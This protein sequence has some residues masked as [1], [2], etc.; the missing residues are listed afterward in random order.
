MKTPRLRLAP[1][2]TGMYH[3]GVPTLENID[4]F[5]ARAG[6]GI[7][8]CMVGNIATTSVTVP[9]AS[10]GI[11]SDNL[12]WGSLA[13]A[14]RKAGSISGIQLSATLPGYR[15]QRSFVALDT[16]TAMRQ[17][18]VLFDQMSEYDWQTLGDK[19]IQS[20]ELCWR[21]G[22]EHVQLHAAH[23][24]A[25]SLI[26][27]PKINPEK[28]GWKALISILKLLASSNQHGTSLRV[29]WHTG[30][31]YDDKRQARILEVWRPFIG[32]IELDLSNG[33]Y[34]LD[35]RHI[36]P[37]HQNGGATFL[38]NAVSLADE[39]PEASLVVAGN[40]WNP[41]KLLETIPSNL[42]ISI[43][44]ALIADPNYL[45]HQRNDK[46]SLMLCDDCGK[47]HFFSKGAKSIECPL[48]PN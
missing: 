5:A 29:S 32:K 26:L 17:Y 8:M 2:N 35:K 34:N 18:K 14:I 31:P 7:G 13:E 15:G 23:G 44:R 27:D 47:C 40:M 43:G 4:F 1:I 21:H 12:S 10:T 36:Y 41:Y 37:P 6:C 24:Y 39:F 45:L 16:E 20:I 19:F 48:W 9:N 22:F 42:N 28:H 33:Y 46:T 3:N 11:M 30:L 38:N 25:F